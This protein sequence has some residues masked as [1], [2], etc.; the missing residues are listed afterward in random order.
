MKIPVLF[1][2]A[3]NVA[4]TSELGGRWRADN[5][6]SVFHTHVILPSS[7]TIKF[8]HG[9][10]NTFFLLVFESNFFERIV[11]ICGRFSRKFREL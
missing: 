11:H 2:K 9:A 1:S 3:L 4:V 6:S 5:I 10:F 8:R 7:R